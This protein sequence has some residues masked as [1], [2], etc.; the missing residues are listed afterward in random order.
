MIVYAIRHTQKVIKIMT[1]NDSC[2]IPLTRHCSTKKC[3][4]KSKGMRY[5]GGCF[6][7]AW[8]VVHVVSVEPLPTMI[9]WFPWRP[10]EIEVLIVCD[11]SVVLIVQTNVKGK[12]YITHAISPPVELKTN[13]IGLVLS[14][15]SPCFFKRS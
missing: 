8:I 10:M 9:L 7:T 2:P 15:L 4:Y 5:D 14:Y 3:M 11:S 1:V 12:L 6:E 13:C